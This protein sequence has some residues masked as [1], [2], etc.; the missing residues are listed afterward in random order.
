MLGDLL[1]F[2]AART[3][4]DPALGVPRRVLLTAA[5]CALGELVLGCFPG[6][7]WDVPLP[8]VGETLT[9]GEELRYEEEREPVSLSTTAR[10]WVEAFALCVVSGL[11]WQRDRVIGP[12]LHE[13]YAPAIRDRVPYSKRE[14]VS[15]PADLAE[16]PM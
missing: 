13:D 12:L 15:A 16:M 10:T 2:A 3:L 1:D 14:P 4:E 7:D 5:E 8:L 9:R 11:V 6:G